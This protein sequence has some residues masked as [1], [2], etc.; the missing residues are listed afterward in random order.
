M[1]TK[2]QVKTILITGG[3]GYIG[4]HTIVELID[5]ILSKK[6][7]LPEAEYKVLTIDNLTNSTEA[8]IPRMNRILRSSH[9]N[10]TGDFFEFQKADITDLPALEAIFL[11]K[12]DAKEPIEY[13]V[14]FAG[15]KS[16]GESMLMPLEYFD[17]NLIGSL[18]LLKCMEKF[19]CKNFIFSSSAT[20]YGKNGDCKEAD[21]LMFA[22]T[23]GCTKLCI[24]HMLKATAQ[25]KS[26]WRV[27]SLRYFNPCGAHESGIIGD[28]PSSLPNNLFP[29]LEDVVVGKR[30]ELSVFGSDYETKDGTGV[31]DYIHVVDL[32][33]AHICAIGKLGELSGYEVYN[34]GTGTGYSVLDIIKAYEKVIQ[35]PIPHKIVG[36]RPGDI[37]ISQCRPEKANRE[38]SW[39]AEKNLE[40]MCRD[41]YRWKSQNPNGFADN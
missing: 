34:V 2:D 23:Y 30:A 25:C 26:D 35:K 32:A 18:N 8:V 9:P 5:S 1:E 7:K 3:T 4:S 33:K 11:A 28:L 39:K 37:D 15:L 29:F 24:E 41:S 12:K 19:Q 10:Q 36:R 17:N 13:I 20:V 22:N 31:R 27:I 14:H 6:V 16:V 21:P 40:D 38:L